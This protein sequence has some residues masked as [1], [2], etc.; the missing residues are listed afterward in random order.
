MSKET[1]SPIDIARQALKQ[2]AMNQVAPT[3][4][5]FRK[6]YEEIAGEVTLATHD[7]NL[8][9]VFDK[10]L[11]EA[12]QTRH[13][14][15]Q[16]ARDMK[17]S[18]EHNDWQRVE[19]QLRRLLKENSIA[20]QEQIESSNIPMLHNPAELWRDLLI[21]LLELG[22]ITQIQHIPELE[23]KAKLLLIKAKDANSVEDI[24]KLKKS[25]ESYWLKLQHNA[26]AS[27]VM[28]HELLNLFQ[29]LVD[30]MSHLA[31]DDDWM[32]G[33]IDIVKNMITQPLSIEMVEEVKGNLG[34][35]LFRQ[36]LLKNSLLDAKEAL[37]RM[38]INCLELLKNVSGDAS[39][40]H[41][42]IVSYQSQINN[43]Q[44]VRT[45]NAILENLKQDMS[46]MEA[47]AKNSY[48]TLKDAHEKIKAADDLV[49]KLAFQL[50]MVS[51]S[52]LQDHLTGALNKR[53]M[54]DAILREFARADSHDKPLCLGLIDIDDFKLINDQLGHVSG[55]EAIKHLADIVN[56]HLRNE[57]VLVR[58]SG[59]TFLI[60][61]PDTNIEDADALLQKIQRE[62]T[63]QLFL[64]E[65]KKHL[66]T[67]SA[68]VTLRQFAEVFDPVMLRAENA[69]YEAKNTGRNK[70]VRMAA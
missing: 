54:E 10:V 57:D 48:Q 44:D 31:L 4:N 42:K 27:H 40:H 13:F 35:L 20:Q 60:I 50:D 46:G 19:F 2:L 36:K 38:A 6:V 30:N 18:L 70:V 26:S 22:L 63:K 55:D 15:A 28:H 25:F 64:Y 53:G 43:T 8:F 24:K 49:E 47:S 56:Q 68:G 45:L 32:H 21:Q 33:Q 17:L 58:Y 37:K 29:L 23:K 52:A 14:Y 59:E 69:L 11:R 65:N 7:A 16:L 5:N 9:N 3:P 62:L 51:Q 41:E 12:G 1:K 67:F 61:L 66:I 39:E 34:A